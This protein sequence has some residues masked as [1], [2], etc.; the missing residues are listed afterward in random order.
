MYQVS[1]DFENTPEM[2]INNFENS[3]ITRVNKQWVKINFKNLHTIG[4]DKPTTC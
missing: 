2:G 4:E 3:H 1:I